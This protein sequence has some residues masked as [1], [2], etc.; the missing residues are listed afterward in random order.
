MKNDSGKT[1]RAITVPFA[2]L[3]CA[4]LAACT[5]QPQSTDPV[6]QV[7][8]TTVEERN[9]RSYIDADG[10]LY[11]ISRAAISS[12]VSAPVHR[13][14][15]RQGDKVK[16]GQ[17]LVTLEN[18]DLAA[19][20]QESRG[21]YEQAQAGFLTTTAASIP[22]QLLKAEGDARA[23]KESLLAAERL[24]ES[25]SA[26]FR[27]G[28]IPRKEVDQAAV[29]LAQAKAQDQLAA[30]HLHSV[31]T[32]T[33]QQDQKS[34]AGQLESAK[35]KYLGSMAQLSYTAVRSPIDGVVTER[36]LYAGEMAQAGAPLITVINNAQLVAR[37]HLPPA[38]ACA[39][40]VG[41]AAEVRASTGG[42]ILSGRVTLVNPATDPNSASVEIWVTVENKKMLLIA[43]TSASVRV[44]TAEAKRALTIP[45]TALLKDSLGE[46]VLVAGT[47]GRAHRRTVKV[48]LE[49]PEEVQILAG[50]SS[51]EQ[52]ITAGGYG[53]DDNTKISTMNASAG[54][55]KASQPQAPIKD[56]H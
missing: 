51:G 4:F 34:A 2:F 21:A 32:V 33:G 18:H 20:V 36:P 45:A 30:G 53:L 25:R 1:V 9:I 56:G 40:K 19:A 49:N 31:Q 42:T 43:G 16:A 12:K 39:I 54:N 10:L 15:V 13:F 52:I 17:L 5:H 41:D 7:Q 27:Q 44:F 48:G 37:L 55:S 14:Y 3:L 11:P 28:A 38:E 50:L 29:A 22:E 8:T 47:D 46:Y 6:A 24:F 23:A 26:L 35:G